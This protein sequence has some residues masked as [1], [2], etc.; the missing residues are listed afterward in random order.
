MKRTAA[1]VGLES[2]GFIKKQHVP[3]ELN[4]DTQ[5]QA[6]SDSIASVDEAEEIFPVSINEIPT[7]DQAPKSDLDIGLHVGKNLCEQTK[8][9]LLTN[10]WKPEK[11]YK[12]PFTSRTYKGGKIVKRYLRLDHLE[13]NPCLAYSHY[14]QGL[15]CKICV[16]FAND[17]GGRGNQRLK[18]L[19][20]E[21][22]QKF[23][24]LFGTDGYITTH[25]SRDY[26]RSAVI[27]AS[28]FEKTFTDKTRDILCKL[29]TS[30]SKTIQEN[31][32][33]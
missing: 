2:F 13:Q 26:H 24:Q 5:P 3:D 11:T 29:D 32:N 10:A 22:L 9:N 18:S 1:G 20:R 14:K 31:R 19:V 30:R 16:L 12:L 33:R 4:S 8:F 27:R 28:N 23:D 21:P 7:C 17:E 6:I 25:V 15:F